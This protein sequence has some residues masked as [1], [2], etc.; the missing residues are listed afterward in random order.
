M[1]KMNDFTKQLSMPL[2]SLQSAGGEILLLEWVN[3]SFKNLSD[4]NNPSQIYLIRQVNRASLTRNG[5][6]KVK[7]FCK[8]GLQRWIELFKWKIRNYR[9]ITA[10]LP[11]LS[12][13]ALWSAFT[14]F[15]NDIS[16]LVGHRLP[17]WP[18]TLAHSPLIISSLAF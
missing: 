8:L 16:L 17:V 14:I 15:L 18:W 3:P 6:K 11:F 1:W 13:A 2:F 7:K 10:K 9:N 5:W 4:S 12:F